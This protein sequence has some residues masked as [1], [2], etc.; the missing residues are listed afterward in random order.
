M[1]NKFYSGLLKLSPELSVVLQIQRQQ[2]LRVPCLPSNPA[3]LGLYFNCYAGFHFP[4][5]TT[6]SWWTWHTRYVQQ[7]NL[8]Q[9]IS[10]QFCDL[11]MSLHFSTRPV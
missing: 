2:S 4:C 9:L 10:G 5:K 8:H 11:S 1:A 7:P 6:S 3:L